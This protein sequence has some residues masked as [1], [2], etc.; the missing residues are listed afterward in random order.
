[1]E[2]LTFV[3]PLEPWSICFFGAPS[4]ELWPIL[5]AQSVHN[6][7]IFEE[8]ITLDLSLDISLEQPFLLFMVEGM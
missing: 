4:P 7:T 5:C 3:L 6:C 8:A 1:M 2:Y